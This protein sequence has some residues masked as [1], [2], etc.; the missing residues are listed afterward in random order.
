[1]A[2]AVAAPASADPE[3]ID[4]RSLPSVDRIASWVRV[5]AGDQVSLDVRVCTDG[6]GRVTSLELL[7]SSGYEPFDRAALKDVAKWRFAASGDA[8]CAKKTIS[9]DAAA[10]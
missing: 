10:K 4:N 5:S 9:Y 8:Q 1:M 3:T 2:L 7:R 6:D